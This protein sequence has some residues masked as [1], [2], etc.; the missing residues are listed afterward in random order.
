MQTGASRFVRGKGGGAWGFVGS[1]LVNLKHKHGISAWKGKMGLL[2]QS[3]PQVAPKG[4]PHGWERPGSLPSCYASSWVTPLVMSIP[5]G[6]LGNGC[7]GNTKLNVMHLQQ[8]S[9]LSGTYTAYTLLTFLGSIVGFQEVCMGSGVRLPG[10][11]F[12]FQTLYCW[13]V[14]SPL[15]LSFP[16]WKVVIVLVLICRNTQYLISVVVNVCHYS[17]AQ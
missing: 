15:C 11:V 8:E 17:Y 2:N 3:A 6:C 1:L 9:L 10:C 7:L 4:K 5:G 12:C 14:T 13:Q 16:I